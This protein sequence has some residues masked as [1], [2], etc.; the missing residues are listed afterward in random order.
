[1]MQSLCD[2]KKYFVKEASSSYFSVP[3]TDYFLIDVDFIEEVRSGSLPILVI[4]HS[5]PILVI[6]RDFT[7]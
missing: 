4:G 3:K 6:V 2:E 5:L 1:M 7:F